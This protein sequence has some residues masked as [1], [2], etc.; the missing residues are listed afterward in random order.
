[1]KRSHGWLLVV[2]VVMVQA[3]LGLYRPGAAQTGTPRPTLANAPEDRQTMIA[4][5]EEIKNL[6]KEQNELL[7]S[8]QLK[9]IVAELPK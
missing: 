3:V 6:L 7:K 2:A 8:G 4:N 5:L 9:V 1:M